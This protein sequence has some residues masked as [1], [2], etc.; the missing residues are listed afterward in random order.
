MTATPWPRVQ[1]FG[2]VSS[3]RVR[4]AS[5]IHGQISH[6]AQVGSAT[7]ALTRTAITEVPAA[8]TRVEIRSA[9]APAATTVTNAR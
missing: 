1:T 2:V 8:T 7:R 5:E 6:N 4:M 9:P 3:A